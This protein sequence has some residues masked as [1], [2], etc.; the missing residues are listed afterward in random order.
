[1]E[2]RSS[3]NSFTG[4]VG[5]HRVNDLIFF[6]FYLGKLGYRVYYGYMESASGESEKMI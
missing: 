5:I 2:V 4:V 3:A 1:M 6:S